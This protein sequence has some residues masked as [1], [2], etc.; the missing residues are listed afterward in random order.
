M[1]VREDILLNLSDL[2]RRFLTSA[3]ALAIDAD[4]EEILVGLTVSESDFFLMFQDQSDAK[5]RFCKMPRFQ[6]LMERHLIARQLAQQAKSGAGAGLKC[7]DDT[8][9]AMRQAV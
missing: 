1:H 6:L 5:E 4:G 2:S 8:F 9:G 3:G 7:C